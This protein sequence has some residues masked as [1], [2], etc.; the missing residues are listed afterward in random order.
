M[1]P[2]NTCGAYKSKVKVFGRNLSP[3]LITETLNIIREVL[4]QSLASASEFGAV[5]LV[6][7]D[8][9]TRTVSVP[10]SH[11]RRTVAPGAVT[12]LVLVLFVL[13]GCIAL[14]VFYW[15]HDQKEEDWTRVPKN[16]RMDSERHGQTTW[17]REFMRYFN[18]RSLARDGSL[19]N[20]APQTLSD[21]SDKASWSREAFVQYSHDPLSQNHLHHPGSRRDPRDPVDAD[22]HGQQT[23]RKRKRPFLPWK[24]QS[25]EGQHI[26]SKQPVIVEFGQSFDP[27]RDRF[28][29][30]MEEESSAP[31]F[32]VF[33]STAP[34]DF[35]F[36]WNNDF[37]RY[38]DDSNIRRQHYCNDDDEC[39]FVISE[40]RIV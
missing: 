33:E 20:T 13:T 36:V 11:N 16:K 38:D 18:N 14:F 35:S 22:H 39:E 28:L 37:G 10:A 1:N 2:K 19:T 24:D 27:E 15:L 17:E 4:P 9:L 12:G 7:Y 21:S 25:Q 30:E 31:P 26:S 5:R 23:R 32:Y 6:V 34:R 40:I 3:D 8:S 29:G